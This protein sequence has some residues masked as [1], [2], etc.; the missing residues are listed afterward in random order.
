MS[1]RRVGFLLHLVVKQRNYSEVRNHLLTAALKDTRDNRVATV[2]N[3][4]S[5]LG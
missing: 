5:L 1:D 3:L 4:F 2:I